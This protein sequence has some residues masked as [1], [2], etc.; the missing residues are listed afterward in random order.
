VQFFGG[1][2]MNIKA[3]ERDKYNYFIQCKSYTSKRYRDFLNIKYSYQEAAE[4][5]ERLRAIAPA[6]TW[7]I[8]KERK[9]TS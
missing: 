9:A 2:K 7:R 3:T 6:F 1:K 4:E 5:L 8:R